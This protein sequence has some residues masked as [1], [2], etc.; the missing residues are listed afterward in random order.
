MVKRR[1]LIVG[2]QSVIPFRYIGQQ[3]N[4]RHVALSIS[5]PGGTD[6]SVAVLVI[7]RVELTYQ[8]I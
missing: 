1:N 3:N 2:Q 6:A 7:P 8:T 5:L 4:F